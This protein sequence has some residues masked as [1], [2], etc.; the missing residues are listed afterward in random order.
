MVIF[1]FCFRTVSSF[2][3]IR[4][5]IFFNLKSY[6]LSKYYWL[7]RKKLCPVILAYSGSPDEYILY[8]LLICTVRNARATKILTV[9]LVHAM[10]ILFIT[11][12]ICYLDYYYAYLVTNN[13]YWISKMK[14]I[15]S[16]IIKLVFFFKFDVFYVKW[17][18][19]C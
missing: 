4:K 8:L 3:S 9:K 16:K 17:A 10:I 7:S 13:N 5:L 1:N 2:K 19:L 15:C 14:Y 11:F 12:Y 6:T 18:V